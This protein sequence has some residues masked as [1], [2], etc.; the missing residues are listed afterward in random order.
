VN[1]FEKKSVK[2]GPGSHL[3]LATDLYEVPLWE[4]WTW[5]CKSPGDLDKV[6]GQN[7]RIQLAICSLP[8]GLG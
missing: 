4:T 3:V 6:N 7:A 1:C 2:V 5:T 8:C